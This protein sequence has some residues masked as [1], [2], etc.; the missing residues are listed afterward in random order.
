MSI[1]LGR[2]Q[3]WCLDPYGRHEVRWFSQGIPTALV[4]DR[5][6]ESQDP[7]PDTSFAHT[8]TMIG[9]A[10]RPAPRAGDDARRVTSRVERHPVR[11]KVD[12]RGSTI[13]E[14]KDLRRR[15]AG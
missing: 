6:L 10:A 7:P 3:N 1:T 4:R 15:P 13:P 14:A 12:R 11:R 5:G 2:A 8:F 9:Y